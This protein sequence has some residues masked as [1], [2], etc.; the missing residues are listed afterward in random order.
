MRFG[1]KLN[2][3]LKVDLH[4]TLCLKLRILAADKIHSI[5]RDIRV[6]VSFYHGHVHYT[7]IKLYYGRRFSIDRSNQINHGSILNYLSNHRPPSALSYM[8]LWTYRYLYKC[9]YYSS[10]SSFISKQH[11]HWLHW[12][13]QLF[14]A[15]LI[16]YKRRFYSNASS[17]KMSTL[18]K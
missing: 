14:L 13:L 11:H 6:H 2:E 12:P 16:Y 15:S 10:M 3:I 5:M 8:S 9:I 17:N 4:Y 18:F 7:F 1:M